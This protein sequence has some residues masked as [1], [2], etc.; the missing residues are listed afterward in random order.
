MRRYP[1]VGERAEYVGR[2]L[3]EGVLKDIASDTAEKLGLSL[4]QLPE[5]LKGYRIGVR[6]LKQLDAVGEK[7]SLPQSDTQNQTP[8]STNDQAMMG[9]RDFLKAMGILAT[10]L[11]MSAAKPVSGMIDYFAAN[12]RPDEVANPEGPTI[13]TYPNVASTPHMIV[14][15]FKGVLEEAIRDGGR[16]INTKLF[17]EILNFIDKELREKK[18]IVLGDLGIRLNQMELKGDPRVKKVLQSFNNLSRIYKLNNFDKNKP[19]VLFISG[20]NGGVF[21]TYD[22]KEFQEDFN[23]A[24]FIYNQWQP[25]SE[26]AQRLH[27]MMKQFKKDPLVSDPIAVVANSLG[28]TVFRYEVLVNDLQEGLFKNTVLI[29]LAPLSGGSASARWMPLAPKSEK[30]VRFFTTHRFDLTMAVHPYGKIQELLFNKENSQIFYEYLEYKFTRRAKGDAH[31]PVKTKFS[32]SKI[33]KFLEN[34]KRDEDGDFA[35][36]DIE[37][38]A[39][40]GDITR[41]KRIIEEV[42]SVLYEKMGV[43]EL[44]RQGKDDAIVRDQAMM[45]GINSFQLATGAT[46]LSPVKKDV[47]NKMVSQKKPFIVR[48]DRNGVFAEITTAEE[49]GYSVT[50]TGFSRIDSMFREAGVNVVATVLSKLNESPDREIV[51]VADRV[52]KGEELKGLVAA[53]K[54]EMRFLDLDISKIKIFGISDIYFKEWEKADPMITFIL[55]DRENV[56]NYFSKRQIDVHMSY[57]GI[58]H[59]GQEA[60][61]INYMRKIKPFLKFHAIVV[62]DYYYGNKNFVE[63]MLVKNGFS[64]KREMLDFSSGVDLFVLSPVDFEKDFPVEGSEN[65]N[66]EV[67][68]LPYTKSFEGGVF[69]LTSDYQRLGAYVSRKSEEL[70]VYIKD[71]EFV[72]INLAGKCVGQVKFI[73]TGDGYAEVD[74][75]RVPEVFQGQGYLYDLYDV[76]F[77][78]LDELGVGGITLTDVINPFQ[79]YVISHV[80]GGLHQVS[81]RDERKAMVIGHRKPGGKMPVQLL[82]EFAKKYFSPGAGNDD[83]LLNLDIMDTYPKDGVLVYVHSDYIIKTHENLK[84]KQRVSV[85]Q[86]RYV[87]D[88]EVLKSQRHKVTRLQEV[89]ADKFGGIDFNPDKLEIRSKGGGVQVNVPRIDIRQLNSPDFTGFTPVIIEIVP[90]TNLPLLIGAGE[91]DAESMVLSRL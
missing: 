33:E 81:A 22:F 17:R 39:P 65:T 75:V 67:R 48:H 23:V 2:F 58:S 13:I 44:N 20:A 83:L 46:V 42:K 38:D 8:E 77:S 3:A 12:I 10:S 78:Y 30:L 61:Y 72:L 11:G 40:H 66:K 74:Y 16:A 64:V 71:D 80:Y 89:R 91:E 62:H 53:L 88:D 69:P 25:L 6:N 79:L 85:A 50:S 27:N 60:E 9:R 18:D 84:L 87:V 24:Y 63:D 34:Y 28:T 7:I 21:T 45:G 41:D 31:A 59:I 86:K 76:F 37:G 55:D 15:P 5:N 57:K 35:E 51:L 36:R 19:T 54:N 47:F 43:K 56:P 70:N 73:F 26:N 52:G 49:Q 14:R 82:G 4:P 1:K 90:V 29:Q 32:G 68:K